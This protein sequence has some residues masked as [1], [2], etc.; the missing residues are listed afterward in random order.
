MSG[1][2]AQSPFS[3]S[4]VSFWLRNARQPAL[5]ASLFFFFLCILFFSPPS[6]CD[7]WAGRRVALCWVCGLVVTSLTLL[8]TAVSQWDRTTNASGPRLCGCCRCRCIFFFLRRR[9]MVCLRPPRRRGWSMG[10]S[11]LSHLFQRSCSGVFGAF[12]CRN[13][14]EVRLGRK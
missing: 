11:L 10:R 13:E 6:L 2:D 4:C 3:F 1:V 5:L 12:V 7:G 9:C 14:L 8:E